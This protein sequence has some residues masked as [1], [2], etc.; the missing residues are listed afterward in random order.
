ML[1]AKAAA[2][3]LDNTGTEAYAKQAQL[4]QITEMIHVARWALS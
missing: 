2:G 4:G 1:I 3:T